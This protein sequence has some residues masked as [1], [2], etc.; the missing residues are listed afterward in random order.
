MRDLNKNTSIE[1][2]N[3]LKGNTTFKAQIVL[4]ARVKPL[5]WPENLF[6]FLVTKGYK[7]RE[8]HMGC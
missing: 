6:E 3:L 2:E 4:E 5:I 7:I 1:G 8:Y